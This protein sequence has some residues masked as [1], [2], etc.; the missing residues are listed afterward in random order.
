MGA[1]DRYRARLNIDG[2][3][4]RQY[5]MQRTQDYIARGLT[6]NL[7]YQHV[8]IND[9]AQDVAVI[10]TTAFDEKTI[11]SLPGETL[12]H[13]GL[14]YWSDSHW[15][16]T[17]IDAHDDVYTRGKMTRCN[18]KLKWID[19][20]GNI[21]SRWAI[22][23]DG[24]KYLI[25]ER[26]EDI[27]T[28]GDARIAVTIGK[29]RD[30]SQ[31]TRGMRFIIDD[32][33]SEEVLCYKISKPNKLF[34]VYDGKGVFRFIMQEVNLT[35]NDNVE[36]RIADYYSW[37]PRVEMPLPD[38]QT[39]EPFRIIKERAEEKEATKEERIEGTKRWL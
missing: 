36:K 14:V 39:N 7:S 4:E 18:Y 6:E 15:L 23:V 10:D 12:E 25:G 17:A 13:G 2:E 35:D 34:N 26:A 20:K 5:L 21:I 24:T 29:D 30:T 16:I 9:V 37:Y 31:L 1:W 22:V 38:D 28:V 3:V 8:T 27:I 33:D 11:C 32:M 19:K